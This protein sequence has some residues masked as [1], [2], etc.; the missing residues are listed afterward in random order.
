MS[1][2]YSKLVDVWVP[3]HFVTYKRFCCLYKVNLITILTFPVTPL[4]FWATVILCGGVC[5]IYT[6]MVG[7]F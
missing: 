1:L 5:V 2:D 4:P 6:V 3:L 7:C